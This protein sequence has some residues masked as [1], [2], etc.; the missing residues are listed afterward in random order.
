MQRA[1]LSE[2]KCP[3]FIMAFT[4]NPYTCIEGSAPKSSEWSIKF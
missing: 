3:S 4:D 2:P 1:K